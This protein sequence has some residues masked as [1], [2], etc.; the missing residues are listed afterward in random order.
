MLL[1][2]DLLLLALLLATVSLSADIITLT[3]RMRLSNHDDI[4]FFLRM[5]SGWIGEVERDFF[6]SRK[7]SVKGVLM[8]C[9]HRSDPEE[10]KE[11]LSSGFQHFIRFADEHNLALVTWTNLR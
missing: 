7:A 11:S 4:S 3:E 1:P 5:P 6:G 2:K 10:V 9:T 8:I